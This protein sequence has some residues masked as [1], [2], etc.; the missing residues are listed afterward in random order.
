MTTELLASLALQFELPR[1]SIAVERV[2]P[3]SPMRWEHRAERWLYPASM[4]KTPLAAVTVLLLARGELDE[5]SAIPVA[6]SNLTATDGATPLDSGY[7]ASLDELLALSVERSDNVAFNQLL[8]VV[9]RE[10]A[11]RLVREEL[12]LRATGLRRKLSGGDRLLVDPLQTGRNTHPARDANRLFAAIARESFPGAARLRAYLDRQQ[13]NT[14]LSRGLRA[15]DR[16]AH[17]TGDTSATSHDGGILLT[18]EGTCYALTVYTALPAGPDA[19][20]RLGAFMQAL[21]SELP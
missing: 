16:F 13:W 1:P 8:D 9:G 14:K 19:D 3:R 12:G 2:D 5:R 7:R 6:A 4:I 21:R 15:G 10:R 11:G 18:A 20:T 17:K